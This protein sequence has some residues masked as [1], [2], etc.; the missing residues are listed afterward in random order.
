MDASAS[1]VTLNDTSLGAASTASLSGSGES[2]N[3]DNEMLI[4]STFK[5]S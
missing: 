4:V 3:E 1:W 2:C 5:L